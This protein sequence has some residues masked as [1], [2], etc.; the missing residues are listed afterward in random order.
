VHF[1]SK[2]NGSLQKLKEEHD[3]LY[4]P[5]NQHLKEEGIQQSKNCPKTLQDG[6]EYSV[7]ERKTL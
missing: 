5:S 4:E 6:M 2:I 3:R 1:K 7:L